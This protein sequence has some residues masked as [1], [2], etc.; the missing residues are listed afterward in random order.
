VNR[1]PYGHGWM[2]VVAPSNPAEADQLLTAE[3]YEAF[4]AEGEQ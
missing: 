1:D 3:Q 4:L 2:L